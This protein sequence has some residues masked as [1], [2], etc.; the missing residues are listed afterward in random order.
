MANN[1]PD[2]IL[3]IWDF[4][5]S[6]INENSDYYPF[7]HLNSTYD[8]TEALLNATKIGC[9]QFVDFQNAFSWPYLFKEHSL[10]ET[11]FS[12]VL[13]TIPVYDECIHI[14]HT[15]HMLQPKCKQLIISNANTVLVE[16]ILQGMKT[17]NGVKF[18]PNVFTSDQIY[19][20]YGWFDE[21]T[22]ILR[23]DRYHNQHESYGNKGKNLMLSALEM[24]DC[25]LCPV[26]LCKGKVLTEEVLKR[27]DI[28]NWNKTKGKSSAI[29][30]NNGLVAGVKTDC[31]RVTVYVGDGDGDY[32][33]VTK[34][35]DSDFAFVRVYD[36]V[37]G[38]QKCIEN[39]DGIKLGCTVFY[40]KDGKEIL[41][42]FKRA[43]PSLQF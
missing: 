30:K 41:Q 26:N 8:R 32:C 21:Q 39:D 23:C 29:V 24:H 42:C 38:L 13:H 11:T 43:L 17:D 1:S 28:R 40:W 16:G 25:S 7:T 2:E 10:N 35:G 36:P 34:L 33:P 20:N 14:V 18:F 22:G 3:V 12:D 4:D 5:W 27:H 9:G 31:E 19:A 37:R 6:M 15:L